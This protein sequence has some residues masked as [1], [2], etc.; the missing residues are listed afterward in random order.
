VII[1][2]CTCKSLFQVCQYYICVSVLN[3]DVPESICDSFLDIFYTLK[4]NVWSSL[5]HKCIYFL[6]RI[7]RRCV[8]SFIHV[9]RYEAIKIRK[10]K[11]I[12]DVMLSL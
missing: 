10:H 2:C 6:F 4:Y 8:F 5:Y 9:C 11:G 3:L 7:V 1:S 12:S